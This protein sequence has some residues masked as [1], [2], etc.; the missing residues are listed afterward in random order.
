MDTYRVLL[1]IEDGPRSTHRRFSMNVPANTSLAA[2]IMA[3]KLGD[4]CVNEP[5]GSFY[6]HAVSIRRLP[7]PRKARSAR[8]HAHAAFCAA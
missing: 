8:A 1:E 7:E 4:Q 3:E 6:T 2:A 5:V